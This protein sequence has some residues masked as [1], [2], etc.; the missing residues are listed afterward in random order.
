LQRYCKTEIQAFT[1]LEVEEE[2]FPPSG[3][4]SLKS[5]AFRTSSRTVTVVF[6]TCLFCSFSIRFSLPLCIST[7]G[8]RIGRNEE[9]CVTDSNKMVFQGQDAWRRHPL[10]QGLWKDPFPGLKKAVVIYG[11]FLCVEFA[12]KTITAPP[13]PTKHA[14]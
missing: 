12:Y 13:K 10:F 11:A 2:D 7:T 4:N 5:T 6:S 3:Q 8:K 14:H 9:C 1:L